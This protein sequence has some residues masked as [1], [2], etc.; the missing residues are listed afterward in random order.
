MKK[1][2]MFYDNWRYKNGIT[3]EGYS[4]NRKQIIQMLEDYKDYLNGVIPDVLPCQYCKT[5]E[6]VIHNTHGL[7]DQ[8]WK[9]GAYVRKP[10][11]NEQTK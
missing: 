5:T 1:C 7:N 6:Y 10:Y 4:L 9:C 3:V 8:C 11:L 2:E